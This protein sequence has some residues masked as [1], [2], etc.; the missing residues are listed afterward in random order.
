[1]FCQHP[2]NLSVEMSQ[3]IFCDKCLFAR[4]G[5][6]VCVQAE[7]WLSP[8]DFTNSEP[9][10]FFH[11]GLRTSDNVSQPLIFFWSKVYAVSISSIHW[12]TKIYKANLLND[13]FYFLRI[14]NQRS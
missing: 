1:M 13:R 7:D 6:S 8:L 12:S 5:T 4:A 10:V 14:Q 3:N 11:F 2:V 9:N